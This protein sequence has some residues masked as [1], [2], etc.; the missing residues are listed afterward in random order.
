MKIGNILME[1]EVTDKK[2]VIP[3]G[4]THIDDYVFVD[5]EQIEEVVLPDSLVYIGIESFC[6]CENLKTVHFGNSLKTI[7]ESAFS[8]C[9]NLYEVKLPGSIMD[10]GD[11]AFSGCDLLM[12]VEITEGDEDMWEIGD[13]AFSHGKSL[14]SIEI[15]KGVEDW[16]EAVFM[17]TEIERFVFPKSSYHHVY[18]SERCFQECL[19][20]QEVVLPPRVDKIEP[21]A[22]LGCSRLSSIVRG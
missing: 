8:G 12:H 11:C 15:K 9:D 13:F 3:E 6:G 17:R 10:I 19:R 7:G 4:I 18:V 5:N 2:V 20:L 1:Y 14:K 21:K 22:F 16:G